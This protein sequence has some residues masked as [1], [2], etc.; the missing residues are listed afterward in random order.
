MNTVVLESV[1][2]VP[3]VMEI[4]HLDNNDDAC[5]LISLCGYNDATI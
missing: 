3:I 4:I 5:D 1:D 2:I